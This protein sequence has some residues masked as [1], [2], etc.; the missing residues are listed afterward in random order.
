[1]VARCTATATSGQPCGA[2][3]WRDGLCPWHHPARAEEMAE[4]CRKGG[5]ARS[6]K[7]RARKAMID[8]ALSPGE[9]Q[10]VIA[11]TLKAVLAGTKAPAIG[12]AVAALSRAAVAV[13]E[14]TEWEER[15]TRLE[16]AAGLGERRRA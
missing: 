6:N 13:R 16:A 12:S 9:L 11:V 14:A 2:H 10:G 1:M 7:A 8:A 3:A 5:R 15:L 4:A